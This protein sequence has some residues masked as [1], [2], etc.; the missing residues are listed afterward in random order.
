MIRLG[1]LVDKPG[2][3]PGRRRP[4]PAQQGPIAHVRA[5]KVEGCLAAPHRSALVTLTGR[6][7]ARTGRGHQV[8]PAVR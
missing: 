1:R 5:V 7:R 8:G 3:S 6:G 2:A 4:D